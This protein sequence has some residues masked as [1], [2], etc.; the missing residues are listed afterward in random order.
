MNRAR[1]WTLR[2]VIVPPLIIAAIALFNVVIDPYSLTPYNLLGIPN[3]FA[4][5]DRTEKVNH[6][7][8]S[9]RY[10]TLMLGSS[11]VYA[12]NPRLAGR[13]LGG[14]VYNAGVGTARPEDHLGFL[15]FLERIGKF[16]KNVILGLDFYSFNPELET[17]S[18]FLRNRELNFLNAAPDSTDYFGKFVSVDALRAS[19]STLENFLLHPE[20]KPRFD[21]Y[22]GA[23]GASEVFAFAPLHPGTATR[24][25]PEKI[26][27]E[28]RFIKTV[29]YPRLSAARLAYL[30]R[31]IALCQEHG[32]RLYLFLTPLQ[33]D[34]LDAIDDD[35]ALRERLLAF[36]TYLH[37]QSGYFDFM[38]H[39]S[40]ND[41]AF[42]FTNPTHTTIE[43]GNLILAKLFQEKH[44]DLPEGFGVFRPKQSRVPAN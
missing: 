12:I 44:L 33:G 7:L 36:K 10:D 16:P 4:R 1:R 23:H 11:R 3:K 41:N 5:D 25:P 31:L 35:P 17:N 6:L 40:V 2:F 15:L 39:N 34:L 20:A 37:A 32:A 27:K 14:T 24:F 13:Y 18:Y 19:A 22:G 43:T 42:Y 8:A 30:K 26:V 29:A 21:R 9:P 28:V 38:T